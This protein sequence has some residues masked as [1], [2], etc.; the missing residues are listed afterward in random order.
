MKVIILG[1]GCSK[2]RTLEERIRALVAKHQL[3]VEVT[4]VTDLQE[5]ITYNIMMTPGLVIDGE[6]KSVGAVPKDDLL[7]QWMKG[8]SQ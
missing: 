2:C 3:A 6:L 5:I 7:L 4:K 8:I 1:P